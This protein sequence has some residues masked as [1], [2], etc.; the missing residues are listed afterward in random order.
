MDNHEEI[1]T[2]FKLSKRGS[3]L[4][5][6]VIARRIEDG[7]VLI[8]RKG[9][10]GGTMQEDIKPMYPKNVG[11]A[12]ETT[13]WQQTKIMYE[14]KILD[15]RD[16][17]Y[18]IIP[19]WD[20]M[21]TKD[22]IQY[23]IPTR[24]TDYMGR[25]RPQLAQKDIEKI[26]LPGYLQRK[27]DG[28]RCKTNWE[29]STD[30]SNV[31]HTWS[32]YGRP[33]LN[34]QH[35]IDDLEPLPSGWFYDGELYHHDRSLQQIVSMVKTASPENLKIQ[36]RVYDLIGTGLPYKK[37]KKVLRRYLRG[38]GPAIHRVK[39]YK[40]HTWEE[41]DALFKRFKEE[42]YEGAMWRDPD[43]P[44]ES[45]ERSW[46]MI[47]VKDFM[48][49][50]FEIVDVEEATGRDAGTALFV[51]I[52]GD[53]HPKPGVEFNVRPMG[54][55][56]ERADY[57][58]NFYEKCEGEMLTVRFQSWTDDGKPFHHRGVIIRNYER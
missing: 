25:L 33:L 29:N 52:T 45:G 37:R 6:E 10:L 47:K 1:T 28:M 22:I 56:E 58:D 49:S 21:T 42:G 50:E 57:L 30:G 14:S 38:A 36:Y 7:A 3:I 26:T 11:R 15:L 9:I 16:K 55:R 41:I 17:S 5:F 48:E 32:K 13:P 46:H 20:E 51:C 44:Y 43:G 35:I 39:T 4:H 12:N 2:L 27:F 18:K 34:L 24:G 31:G 54:T 40:V 53:D 23:L 8:T 19:S